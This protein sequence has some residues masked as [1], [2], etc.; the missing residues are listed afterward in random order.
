MLPILILVFP[1]DTL[2]T[3]PYVLLFITILLLAVPAKVPDV[4][5]RVG[6]WILSLFRGF[7]LIMKEVVD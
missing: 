1:P 3:E 6:Y 5:R 2:F 7:E 4:P